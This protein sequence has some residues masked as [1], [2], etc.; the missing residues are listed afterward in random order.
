[1]AT[2]TLRLYI[3]QVTG[4]KN[5]VIKLDSDADVLP[6]EHE[7][8]HRELVKKM[9]SGVVSDNELG[10]ITIERESGVVSESTPAQTS[11]ANRQQLAN[12]G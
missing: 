11:V 4:K 2:M 5:V 9:L 1:M 8:H 6:M 3:D 12:K 7:Q 10:I